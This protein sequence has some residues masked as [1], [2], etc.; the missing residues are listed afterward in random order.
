MTA[1][2]NANRHAR[3]YRKSPTQEPAT[4]VASTAERS[5][6]RPAS[7]NSTSLLRIAIPRA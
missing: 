4:L 1:Y 7:E 3:R 2:A 6:L 5:E